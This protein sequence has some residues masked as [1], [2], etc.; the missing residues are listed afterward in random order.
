M[1]KKVITKKN[2]APKVK[3]TMSW[4][5]K[6][7]KALDNFTLE[8]TFLDKTQGVV[9]MKRLI[10]SK[11]AGVFAKLKNPKV[12]SK[13]FVSLGVVTWPGEIDLAPDAMYKA[14]RTH[15]VWIVKPG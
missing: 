4:R 8:V 15:H 12:F 3:P 13:V 6:K 14:I 2:I 9:D 5:V 7:V 1:P 11:K 10:K